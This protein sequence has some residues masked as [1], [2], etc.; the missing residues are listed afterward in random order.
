MNQLTRKQR[1][2]LEREQLILDMAQ[3]IINEEGYSHLNMDRIAARVEYSKGTIYNH[4][5]NKEE[6]I[7]GISCRCMTRLTRLFSRAREYPGSH[8]ERIAAIGIA[9]SLYTLL[10]P[11][12]MQ[13]MQIIKSTGVREKISSDKHM[14]LMHQE[15]N[16]TG[17]VL[18]IIGDAMAAGDI[19]AGEAYT[20]DGIMFGLWSMSYGA[21]LLALT[22]IPFEKLG[23]ADPL[24]MLWV[25]CHKLLDSYHWKPLSTDMDIF[26]LREKILNELFAEEY[27]QLK[28]E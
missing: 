7:S 2:L 1:E 28:G 20:P 9:H 15:E 26:A 6:I 5:S 27:K 13:N 21:N 22:D 25:N 19:P 17:V 3:S 11:N 24:D 8:R 18:D 12:E 23:M 4:F 16:V 14:E 10:H